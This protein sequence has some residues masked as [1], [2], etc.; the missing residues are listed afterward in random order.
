MTSARKQVVDFTES[1]MT[2]R[3]AAVLLKPSAPVDSSSTS[4]EHSRRRE[5]CKSATAESI[6]LLTIC[7][8]EFFKGYMIVLSQ[9]YSSGGGTSLGG[10]LCC[11]SASSCCGRYY[12]CY[13]NPSN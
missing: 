4:S 1:F 5:F 7:I 3:S 9:F 2:M 10:G 11:I 12:R 8:Q 6:T 13:F